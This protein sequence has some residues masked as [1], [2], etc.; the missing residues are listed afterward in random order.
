MNIHLHS[1]SLIRPVKMKKK[2]IGLSKIE[3][4]FCF[5]VE[6]GAEREIL[7]QR[8]APAEEREAFPLTIGK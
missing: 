2:L 4:F 7:L 3:T 1:H 6:K 5:S 8:A